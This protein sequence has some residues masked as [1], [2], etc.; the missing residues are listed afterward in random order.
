MC[1][2]VQEPRQDRGALAPL[3]PPVTG[4]V[5]SGRAA[6]LHRLGDGLKY[7]WGNEY[8]DEVE[9]AKIAAQL[10]GKRVTFAHPEASPENHHGSVEA[11]AQAWFVGE[12]LSARVDGEDVV[13]RVLVTDERA[14]EQIDE[15][16]VIELSLGYRCR[17][18]DRGFQHDTRVDHLAIVERGRCGGSCALRVDDEQIDRSDLIR[19]EVVRIQ[20]DAAATS[21]GCACKPLATVQDLGQ[22]ATHMPT[23]ELSKQLTDA[24]TE[25]AALKARAEA[26]EKA[27]GE[28]KSRADVAEELAFS[29]KK[30]LES[31]A[32]AD[33][34]AVDVAVA[35][36]K[37]RADKAILDEKTRADKA[38]ADLATMRADTETQVAE[39]VSARVDLLTKVAP[40]EMKDTEGK[41]LDFSKMSDRD[42]KIAAIIHVDGEDPEFKPEW[43]D[44]VFVGAMKRHATA[45]KS[46]A[47]VETTIV[48]MRDVETSKPKNDPITGP[49]AKQKADQKLRTDLSTQWQKNPN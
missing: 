10:P 16:G 6:R 35:A 20:V 25:N 31:R 11:G 38:E 41:P 17:T 24:Q 28:Q 7:R 5:F 9:L 33:Q 4:R 36:E 43:A 47:E 12:V 34:K 3:D 1:D 14:L 22:S 21:P 49:T 8:R 2:V 37:A 18:D 48:E 30:E 45:A 29:R 42:I 39:R 40:L 23:D 32:D 15:D 13:V 44:G 46:R 26:A 27:L 19:H